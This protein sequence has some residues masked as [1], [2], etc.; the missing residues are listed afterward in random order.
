MIKKPT[1]PKFIRLHADKV[2]LDS[3]QLALYVTIC[4]LL[5]VELAKL[6]ERRKI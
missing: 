2:A 4:K 6:R 5:H 3:A 1:I